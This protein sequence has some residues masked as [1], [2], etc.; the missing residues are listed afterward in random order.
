MQKVGSLEQRSYIKNVQDWLNVSVHKV[1]HSCHGPKI[2]VSRWM[3]KHL[4]RGLLVC[5]DRAIDDTS[6][7]KTPAV[8]E[9]ATAKMNTSIA[10]RY[11]PH[12]LFNS[13]FIVFIKILSSADKIN[14]D[15]CW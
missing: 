2:Y 5:G 8:L 6:T 11:L 10:I 14:N 9:T 12:C 15:K 3:I 7:Q 4:L 13:C 1:V